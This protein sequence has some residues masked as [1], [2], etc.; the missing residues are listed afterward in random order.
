MEIDNK[1][2]Q[3]KRMMSYF[4]KATEQVI[5]EEGIDKV[6]IRK[7]AQLAA[8]NS[9]TLYNY[10]EDLDHLVFYT[11]MKYLKAYTLGLSA[12]MAKCK[13][14]RE[15]VLA[16]W[17]VFCKY[18]FSKPQIFYNLFFNKHSDKFSETLKGYYAIFPE[19]LGEH[20]NMVGDMLRQ[21]N[22]FRRNEVLLG[23]LLPE[24]GR[25]LQRIAEP[26]RIMVYTLQA[27]LHSSSTGMDTR[28]AE[29]L[30]QEMMDAVRYLLGCI[31]TMESAAG[32]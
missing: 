8:Y 25:D 23:M 20:P 11:L 9:A 1:Q 31:D 19:E 30:R 17:E 7:V 26:N 21:S 3:R 18:A 13:T 29:E 24:E 5:E 2:V 4:I 16:S 6:T 27:L 22:M 28:P 12:A 10:F 32:C 14:P 15:V